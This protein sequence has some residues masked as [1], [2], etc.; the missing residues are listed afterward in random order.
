MRN[1]LR[2]EIKTILKKE[3]SR[4]SSLNVIT[5]LILNK[6]TEIAEDEVVEE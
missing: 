4:E 2:K 3:K 6:L 5:D 1:R